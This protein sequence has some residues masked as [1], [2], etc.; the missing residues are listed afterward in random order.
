MLEAAAAAS[1]EFDLS[2]HASRRIEMHSLFGNLLGIHAYLFSGYAIRR[3]VSKDCL[4]GTLNRPANA[5]SS[6]VRV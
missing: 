6:V 3:P 1:S 2:G 4:A 5:G